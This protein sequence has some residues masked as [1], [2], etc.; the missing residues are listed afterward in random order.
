MRLLKDANI[1][2]RTF[3]R[4]VV[5]E[6]KNLIASFFVDEDGEPSEK[7]CFDIMSLH[8]KLT[9]AKIEIPPAF[10]D[11]IGPILLCF[12]GIP[13]TK[14]VVKK[15]PEAESLG[16]NIEKKEPKKK[17]VKKKE[18]HEEEVKKEVKPI[19]VTVYEVSISDFFKAIETTFEYDK[20]MYEMK[21]INDPDFA[22]EYE[23]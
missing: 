6:N 1:T 17:K 9:Q 20:L 4:K 21:E 10:A 2:V 5:R 12:G 8:K 3:L 11:K 18:V 19:D 13:Y 14:R 23:A 22:K 7:R 15:M 16:A